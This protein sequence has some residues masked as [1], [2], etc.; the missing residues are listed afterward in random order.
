VSSLTNVEIP[1]FICALSLGVSV[2]PTLPRKKL[3]PDIE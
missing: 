1:N 2:V 3:F